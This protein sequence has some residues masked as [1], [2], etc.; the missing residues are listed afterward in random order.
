MS[1]NKASHLPQ[2]AF[3]SVCNA[4]DPP[5]VQISVIWTSTQSFGRV[6]ALS[7]IKCMSLVLPDG[8]SRMQGSR[9]Q[10]QAI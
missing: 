5:H 1:S 4:A 7:Y 3:E 2:L 9:Q 10:N 8:L 6:C